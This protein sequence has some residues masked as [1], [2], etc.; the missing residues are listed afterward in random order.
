MHSK[1]TLLLY[2]LAIICLEQLLGKNHFDADVYNNRF[3]VR[4]LI[5]F[6]LDLCKE[7]KKNPE[8]N[9]KAN[10]SLKKYLK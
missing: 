10:D 3:K 7:M 9:I 8:A 6:K 4:R 5:K 1:Y 2:I